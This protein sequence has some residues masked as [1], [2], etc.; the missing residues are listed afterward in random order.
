[1]DKQ[2]LPEPEESQFG[3]P[4][5]MYMERA[6]LF[7]KMKP[8][9]I[10]EYLKYRLQGYTKNES[11]E[12]V[13]ED[14][15]KELAISKEG[16]IDLTN[17]AIAVLTKTLTITNLNFEEIKVR[18]IEITKTIIAKMLVNWKA[19]NINSTSQM[20]AI[21]TIICNQT[22]L[23]FKEALDGGARN[24]IRG[25]T[26][27]NLMRVEQSGYAPKKQGIMD[28]ILGRR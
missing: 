4:P 21:K 11:G 27:E 22:Y 17:T 7:E 18:Q 15:S 19:Y 13:L 6:D 8:E 10:A 23:A 25:V 20:R 3:L 2:P 1:M 12:W 16:A 24:L 9:S 26:Q 28:K 5:Q 14:G